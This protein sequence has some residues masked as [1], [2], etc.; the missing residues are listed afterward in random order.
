[1]ARFAQN[2]VAFPYRRFC[3]RVVQG[4][5]IEKLVGIGGSGV[6]FQA[7]A[8]DGQTVALKLLRPIRSAYDLEAVWREVEPLQRISDPAVP[9]WLGIVRD[10]RAYF[11]VLSQMKGDSLSSWLFEKKHS[12]SSDEMTRLAQQ[13]LDALVMLHENGLVHGDLRPANILY[14]GERISLV[15]FGMSSSLSDSAVDVA[16]FGDVLLYLLYSSFDSSTT[17]GK[18]SPSWHEELALTDAQRTF[19][20]G[21]FEEPC[22]LSMAEVRARFLKAFATNGT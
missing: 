5:R 9:Q 16:G 21:V 20:E 3:G 22:T 4:Y 2:I 18:K 12:F 7:I 13:L 10:K 11:I 1:M 17:A 19:L 15:D 14:D 6:V 8:P